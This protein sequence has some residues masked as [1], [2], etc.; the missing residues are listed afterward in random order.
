MQDMAPNSGVTPTGVSRVHTYFMISHSFQIKEIVLVLR[1]YRL[2]LIWPYTLKLKIFLGQIRGGYVLIQIYDFWEYTEFLIHRVLFFFL[3][4]IQSLSVKESLPLYTHYPSPQL[5]L[6]LIDQVGDLLDAFP[7]RIFLKPLCVTVRLNTTI[8][9][10]LPHKCGQLVRCR[11]FNVVIVAFFSYIFSSLLIH[12]FEAYPPKH[13]CILPSIHCVVEFQTPTLLFEEVCL[14]GKHYLFIVIGPC[15]WPTNPLAL[16][17]A[18]SS[19]SSF[20]SSGMTHD[21]IPL[22]GSL[23]PTITTKELS[24]I[25]FKEKF[26]QYIA[27]TSKI[28]KIIK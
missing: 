9:A 16:S 15:P 12:L 27:T 6:P 28:K 25:I 22:L 13:G 4:Q 24:K 7:I 1:P 3:S 5:S 11:V 10:S 23:I 21:P 26:K 17:N 18:W 19:Q 2:F 8:Q 14:L 20:A